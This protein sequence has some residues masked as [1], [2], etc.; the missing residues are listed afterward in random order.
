MCFVDE[1]EDFVFM[2]EWVSYSLGFPIPGPC[3]TGDVLGLFVWVT[4]SFVF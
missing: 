1:K 2:E 4:S 3:F